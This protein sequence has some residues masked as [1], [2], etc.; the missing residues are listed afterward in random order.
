M[1]RDFTEG[2]CDYFKLDKVRRI[3][4]YIQK[5][6]LS[7][8][9]AVSYADSPKTAEYYYGMVY[10]LKKEYPDE[11]MVYSPEYGTTTDGCGRFC[12]FTRGIIWRDK[13][14]Y[15]N[16]AND[17]N[18]V[19]YYDEDLSWVIRRTPTYSFSAKGGCNEEHH[20][21]NDVGTFIFARAGY[22]LITDLGS[23]VYT[24]HYGGPESEVSGYYHNIPQFGDDTQQ[25]GAQFAA[26]DVVYDK[27]TFTL[28][29]AGAYGIPELKSLKR[30][31]EI[32]DN[33]L[34]LTDKFDYN[35]EGEITE[36]FILSKAPTE[37]VSGKITLPD[38]VILY[39]PEIQTVS[40]REHKLSREPFFILEFKLSS[41][42]KEFTITVK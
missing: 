27:N 32:G 13:E 6:F 38:G 2:R 26:S 25:R 36:R 42:T 16:P 17:N 24:A 29:I 33:E 31:F 34:T 40:V 19:N 15:L 21:H 9:S 18:I 20:N 8:K 4:T 41:V 1:L 12:H 7:G 23:G 28:D 10:F 14:I 11:V 5:I 30:S 37:I 22:Q 3:A 35:G 39:N